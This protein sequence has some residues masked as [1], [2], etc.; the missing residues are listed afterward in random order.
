[1]T[2]FWAVSHYAAIKG[3]EQALRVAHDL[4]LLPDATLYS[5][6]PLFLP[7]PIMENQ[8][9]APDGSYGYSYRG[10]KFLFVA[11]H[12]YF[13]RPSDPARSDLNIVVPESDALRLE[14]EAHR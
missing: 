7:P 5:T 14:L 9:H 6:K 8:M 2:I 10:L 1:M 12:K 11:N 4:P 13:F 3:R